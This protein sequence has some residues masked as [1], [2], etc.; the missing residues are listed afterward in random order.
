[1]NN[2]NINN[3][4][5]HYS[6][7]FPHE[8]LE[9]QRKTDGQ[10]FDMIENGEVID[11]EIRFSALDDQFIANNINLVDDVNPD[12][13]RI[14]P[15]AWS[16][17]SGNNYLLDYRKNSESPAVLVMDHEEAMVREDAESESETSEEAQQLLEE[18]VR[19]IADNFNAFIAC[20]KARPS[21]PVE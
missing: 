14:I 21:D 20:L 9:F 4:Q 12:P 2:L 5:K 13:S 17:S 15:F 10:A 11:W 7:V 1:M 16:V 19:E 8:Y 3:I 18:N 6:I